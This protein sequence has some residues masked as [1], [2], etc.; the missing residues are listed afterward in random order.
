MNRPRL[1]RCSLA[2]AYFASLAWLVV[3]AATQPS[4]PLLR[5]AG[6]VPLGDKLGHFL[7]MGMLVLVLNYFLRGRALRAGPVSI[8]VG[9]AAGAALIFVE[10]LSQQWLPL[11]TFSAA[12]L[13]A[14]ALGV[15]V[16]DLVSRRWI[17]VLETAPRTGVVT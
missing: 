9:T 3:I 16:F 15:L 5:L 1:L 10:E 14:D 4:H 7:L 11:R 6:A 13:L 12:D 8:L 17:G 2:A